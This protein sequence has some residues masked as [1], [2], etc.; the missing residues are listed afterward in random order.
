[1]FPAIP[2]VGGFVIGSP[3]FPSV[4]VRLAGDRLLRIRAPGASDENRYVRGLK[5]N[6]AAHDSPWIDWAALSG[7][8]MLDF[9]L[10]SLPDKSWG[11][12]TPPPSFQ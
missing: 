9:A 4:T 12:G 8:G 6:G 11:A 7:G 1:L 3:R 10:G 5:L 2:G